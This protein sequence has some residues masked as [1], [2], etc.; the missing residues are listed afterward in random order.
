VRN[1]DDPC[2]FTAYLLGDE[3]ALDELRPLAAACGFDACVSEF[4]LTAERSICYV[5]L[6]EDDETHIARSSVAVAW[7]NVDALTEGS[8]QVVL[9]DGDLTALARLN[10]LSSSFAA[11]QRFNFRAPIGFDIVDLGTTIFIHLGLSYSVL[12]N[13]AG[14]FTAAAN[15]RRQQKTSAPAVD[16]HAADA[17]EATA[18]PAFPQP[19]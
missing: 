13:F 3:A 14:L 15:V 4:P 19:A 16:Q 2:D 11:T 10:E 12:F 17:I 8:T 7:R 18:A 9:M 6:G 5:G 1:Q